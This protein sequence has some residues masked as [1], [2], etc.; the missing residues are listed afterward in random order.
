MFSERKSVLMLVT[1][2]QIAEIFSLNSSKRV[3]Q[4]R[5]L[6]LFATN[7]PYKNYPP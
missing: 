5:Y 2:Q 1:N 4:V 3:K 7:P 6:K